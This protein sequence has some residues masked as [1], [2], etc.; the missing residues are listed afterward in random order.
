MHEPTLEE[1]KKS[2]ETATEEQLDFALQ[3]NEMCQS[4]S[5]AVKIADQYNISYRE[6]VIINEWLKYVFLGLVSMTYALDNIL[7]ITG[8]EEEVLYA[9]IMQVVD[10][11]P[12][13]LRD[14]IKN[15]PFN[16]D[17]ET[18]LPGFFDGIQTNTQTPNKA[19]D[20][21]QILSDLAKTGEDQTISITKDDILAGI[22][23]PT[24]T[25]KTPS[26]ALPK[27]KPQTTNILSSLA[28]PAD[29][30]K[31]IDQEMIQ[32]GEDTDIAMGAIID[33]FMKSIG[34]SVQTPNQIHTSENEKRAS[35][36]DILS[37]AT[38]SKEQ[39]TP[40]QDIL[41]TM[42]TKLQQVQGTTPTETY[43]VADVPR[44]DPY[45]EIPS[46]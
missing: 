43:K 29:P 38:T 44:H 22:E 25:V 14:L 24:E 41:Q 3:I 13:S 30:V 45:R 6:M 16:K 39:N 7:T 8:K 18:E 42:N 11:T 4:D 2:T 27:S 1:I 46:M 9:Y 12:K 34:N 36:A 5:V 40:A 19:Q 32:S 21:A 17:I 20:T 33:P 37:Q 28:K 15:I 23:N 35:T 10:N 31:S 26:F